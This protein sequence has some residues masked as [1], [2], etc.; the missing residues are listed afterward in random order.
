MEEERLLVPGSDK[1]Q[2]ANLRLARANSNFYIRKH[3]EREI[4]GWT[5]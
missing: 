1:E 4:Y 5:K 2:G 3:Y